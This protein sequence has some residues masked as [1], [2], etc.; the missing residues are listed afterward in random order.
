MSSLFL[1]VQRREYEHQFVLSQPLPRN[2]PAS[3]VSTSEPLVD[4]RLR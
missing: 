2:T 4:E 3:S 1:T